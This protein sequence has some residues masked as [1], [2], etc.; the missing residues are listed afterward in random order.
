MKVEKFIKKGERVFLLVQPELSKMYRKTL[1]KDRRVFK[2]LLR[3]VL[4][5]FECKHT[6]DSS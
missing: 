4:E 5:E 3:R 2:I 6:D 1:W